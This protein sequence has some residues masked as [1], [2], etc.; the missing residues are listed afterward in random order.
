MKWW[1]QLLAFV[2]LCGPDGK[3][4]FSKFM[5]VAVLVVSLYTDTFGV[6]VA[7]VCV[8]AAFG[9]AV[10]MALINRTSLNVSVSEVMTRVQARRDP[11][12]GI[13][14]TK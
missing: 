2:D 7:L 1:M 4:S 8:A 3:P 14:E 5:T 9:R 11:A 13:E 12:L 6:G 10:L